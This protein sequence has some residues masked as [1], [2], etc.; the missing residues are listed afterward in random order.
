VFGNPQNAYIASQAG[1]SLSTFFKAILPAAVA[2]IIVN[3][4]LLYFMS[5][6]LG[7]FR[8]RYRVLH[9]P[10]PAA[11]A[12]AL[13]DAPTREESKEPQTTNSDE[14]VSDI[15]QQ[16]IRETAVEASGRVDII[17]TRKKKVFAGWLIVVSLAV[18]GLL[19]IPPNVAY[20]SLGLV[21]LGAA[22]SCMIFDAVLNKINPYIAITH[23]VDWTVIVMFMGLFVWDEGFEVTGYPT[24]AFNA[25]K[26]FLDVR[27]VS[28]IS[29]FSL[30]VTVGSNILS[31]VPLVILFIKELPCI[32]G[33]NAL[34]GCILA[35]VSTVA[36][37]LT[38]IGSV[39]NLIVAEKAKKEVNYTLGFRNYI[40]FGF[41]STI[42]V[43][44]I[45][46]PIVRL[47]A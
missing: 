34:K 4:C 6:K 18:V 21:P 36:G 31:N 8:T 37:N 39:A 19:A 46:V 12:G 35:W 11:A 41:P 38:L 23:A 24:K 1:V 16:S 22:I 14:D 43:I 17:W 33:T 47:L 3:T 32:Y 10:A 15:F 45:G 2:G 42:L 40:I 7:L 30:V 27:K 26:H 28:G 9:S 25:V 44:T 20:F 29:L 13:L 5:W